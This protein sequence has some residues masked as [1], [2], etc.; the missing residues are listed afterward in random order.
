MNLEVEEILKKRGYSISFAA[1][2]EE[3]Q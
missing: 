1:G 2:P 3:L